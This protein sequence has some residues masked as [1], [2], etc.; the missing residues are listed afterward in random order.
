MSSTNGTSPFRTRPFASAIGRTRAPDGDGRD[1]I[2]RRTVGRRGR[3]SRRRAVGAHQRRRRTAS[4]RPTRRRIRRPKRH[5][6]GREPHRDGRPRDSSARGCPLEQPRVAAR[7]NAGDPRG[8]RQRR[9]GGRRRVSLGRRR[10]RI[11]RSSDERIDDPVHP[12]TGESE[13]SVTVV[14]A[15]GKTDT[16]STSIRVDQVG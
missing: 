2:R 5:R 8:R 3:R 13:P 7:G 9:S 1:R 4:R 6:H 16:D 12:D 10:R 15:V 11:D 14:D